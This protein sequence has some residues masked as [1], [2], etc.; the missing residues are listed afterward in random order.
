MLFVLLLHR[1]FSLYAYM[2]G[3]KLGFKVFW[4]NNITPSLTL[5]VRVAVLQHSRK[6]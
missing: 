4:K 6:S 2:A 1:F 3:G 5:L